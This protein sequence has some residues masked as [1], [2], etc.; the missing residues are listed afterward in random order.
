VRVNISSAISLPRQEFDAESLFLFAS[1]GLI[2]LLVSGSIMIPCNFIFREEKA[3]LSMILSYLA[4]SALV[5]GYILIVN[6]FVDV[7]THLLPVCGIGAV[8]SI[9]IYLISWTISKN[10]V[11][12]GTV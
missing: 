8:V 11:L 1:I 9:V 12:S 7:Q 4:T 2:V 3:M 5:V 10:R 6:L